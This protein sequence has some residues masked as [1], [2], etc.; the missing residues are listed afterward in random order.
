[1][2]EI[3]KQNLPWKAVLKQEYEGKRHRDFVR[4][5]THLPDGVMK[6]YHMQLD[7]TDFVP[8]E[9]YDERDVYAG[10]TPCKAFEVMNQG[11]CGSCYAFASASAFAARLCRAN[12]NS[13]N[14]VVI[15]PQEMM[16]CNNGC[17]GG[18]PIYVYEALTKGPAV[19]EWCDPYKTVKDTCGTVCGTGNQYFGQPN[20]A[21]LVGGALSDTGTVL[22]MQLELLRG[23]PG[24][25]SLDLMSDIGAY[26]SGVY[27]VSAGATFLGGHAV[28][29]VGW[30]V[31]GGV[32]Y[33]IMQ[34]SYGKGW[35][36]KGF[37]RMRRGT[38][39]CGMEKSGIIVVKPVTPTACPDSTCAPGSVTL[40]DCTCRCDN[41]SMTGPTCSECTLRCS[42]GG[43][44]DDGCTRCTCPPG[45]FG[46]QCEGGY[47]F[48]ALAS[49]AEVPAPITITYSFGGSVA[50]PTQASY[51]GIFTLTQ[52]N[53]FKYETSSFICG[54]KYDSAVNG[55]LCPSAGSFTVAPPS[56]VGEYRIVVI[57]WQPLNAFGQQG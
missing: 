42:N 12:R 52:N 31:E 53:G 26:S 30:G 34:N 51:V 7:T 36:E 3:N 56:A 28:M 47:S 20:S 9:A 4:G 33:W 13:V 1:V 57:P 35:A 14:N 11:G 23:G 6:Q 25:V 15:S 27:V 5:L 22:Q 29:L 48:S 46:P 44:R 21:R 49:C 19:E 50:A 2:E 40:K 16:D 18:A 10:Q 24:V 54:T 41:P 32:P 38:N 37:F 8:P 43:V 45:F 55:G 17:N 39:E